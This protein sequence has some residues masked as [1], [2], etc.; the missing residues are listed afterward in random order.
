LSI[1]S[2]VG[3]SD[4]LTNSRPVSAS[5]AAPPQFAPPDV[6]GR[7]SVPRSDGGVTPRIVMKV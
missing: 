2:N 7:L 5:K 3:F 6:D 4:D 1:L